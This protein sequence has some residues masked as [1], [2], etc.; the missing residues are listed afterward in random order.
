VV[1]ETSGPAERDLTTTGIILG[2]PGFAAPEVTMGRPYD[3]R[4]DQ[5]AL[6]V[7][8]YELLSGRRAFSGPSPAAIIVEQTTGDAA[9]LESIISSL[10]GSFVRRSPTACRATRKTGFPVV[11]I[12]AGRSSQIWM[13]RQQHRQPTLTAARRQ[14][15]RRRARRRGL[16]K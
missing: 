9:S 4:A 3:G 13:R 10:I 7:T 12:S 2:T 5:Y 1:A 11:P 14:R 8:I 16:T 6:A 15:F